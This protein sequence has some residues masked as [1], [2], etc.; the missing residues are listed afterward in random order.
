MMQRVERIRPRIKS[1]KTYRNHLSAGLTECVIAEVDRRANAAG[2]ARGR[3]IGDL[4]LA[5]VEDLDEIA[6]R[7]TPLSTTSRSG[8]RR[9]V[10]AT[11]GEHV[12]DQVREVAA[13]HGVALGRIVAQIVDEA[14]ADNE[15]GNT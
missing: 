7:V 13:R 3:Y 12:H 5:Q 15:D 1:N 10:A 14:L 9:T 6:N 4:I 11:V 2:V 8:P